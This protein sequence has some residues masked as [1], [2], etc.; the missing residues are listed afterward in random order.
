MKPFIIPQA[1]TQWHTFC[2][3][4]LTSNHLTDK[5]YGKKWKVLG[6]EH[7]GVRGNAILSE[8]GQAKKTSLYDSE[9]ECC[10]LQAADTSGAEPVADQ[11]LCQCVP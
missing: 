10:V 11:S 2:T 8:Q 9:T 1:Q 4:C 7:V 6:M 5:Y 3:K